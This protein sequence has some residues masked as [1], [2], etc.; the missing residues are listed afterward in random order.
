MNKHLCNWILRRRLKV[1]QVKL[2]DEKIKYL[3]ASLRN[4]DFGSI[5]I[6]VHNGQIT[7][8]DTTEKKRFT[9]CKLSHSV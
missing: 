2:D 7:Q 9:N 4:I 3:T 8:I 1:A 6:T 5:V